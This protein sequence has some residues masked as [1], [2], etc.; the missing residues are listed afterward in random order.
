MGIEICGL[1]LLEYAAKKGATFD[2]VCTIGRQQIQVKKT[3]YAKILN[4][5]GNINRLEKLNSSIK[6][7][8]IYGEYYEN[9][10]KVLFGSKI[11]DSIDVN[12]FEGASIIHDLNLPLSPPNKIYSYH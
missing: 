4:K 8:E 12:D 5:T 9:I 3:E 1:S 11:T 6:N 2:R 10:F 7:K